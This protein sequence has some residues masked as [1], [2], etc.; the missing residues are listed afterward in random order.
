MAI[1]SDFNFMGKLMTRIIITCLALVALFSNA[2]AQNAS[3]T[4]L[5]MQD[6]VNYYDIVNAYDDYWVSSGNKKVKHSGHKQF[7]RWRYHVEP[8][9][10]NDGTIRSV[11]DIMRVSKE[12]HSSNASR[13]ANGSWTEIGPWQEENYSRGVG[14]MSHIAFHPTDVNLEIRRQGVNVEECRQRSSKFW[15]FVYHL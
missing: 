12:Y 9:V 3:W 5:M 1:F 2:S 15:S 4:E 7:E 14:R 10:Q 13:S 11:K 8:R 6:N